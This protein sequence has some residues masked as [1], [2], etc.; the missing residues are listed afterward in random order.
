MVNRRKIDIS[1]IAG[2]E[3]EQEQEIVRTTERENVL[4]KA[5]NAL[6]KM[7]RADICNAIRKTRHSI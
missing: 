4:E 5:A 3:V 6:G 7:T 1:K 2:E